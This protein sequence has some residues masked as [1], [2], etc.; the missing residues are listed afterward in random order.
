MTIFEFF[1]EVIAVI[2][3]MIESL[4]AWIATYFPQED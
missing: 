4:K 3:L 1:E 2:N